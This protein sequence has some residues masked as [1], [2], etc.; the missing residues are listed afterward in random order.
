[1]AIKLDM[2]KAYD[3]VEWDAVMEILKR[4]GF[5]DKWLQMIHQCIATFQFSVLINGCPQGCFQASRGIRQG[6]PL[7][8]YLFII[9]S[10]ALSRCLIKAENLKL[11]SGLKASKDAPSINHLLYA[12]DL[13]LFSKATKEESENLL[14][15]VKVYCRATG[16]AVNFGKSAM[17]SIPNVHAQ[18]QMFLREMWGVKKFSDGEKYLGTPIM[19][20]KNKSDTFQY[21]V[22]KMQKRVSGRKA[23]VLS[24]AGRNVLINTVAKSIHVYAMSTYKL[25]V[26]ICDKLENICRDFWWQGSLDSNSVY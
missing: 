12:D 9:L 1:M 23:K 16:Q 14:K 7:S 15:I 19:L 2:A 8:P 26:S 4:L 13:I 3:R 17:F 6:N 24:L 5:C 18:H 11:I 20:G 10:E 21:L 25:P 22:E